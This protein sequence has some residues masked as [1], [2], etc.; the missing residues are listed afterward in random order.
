MSP[1]VFP[2]KY[3]GLP[4]TWAKKIPSPKNPG[5]MMPAH[6][7]SAGN[8]L[9]GNG[10]CPAF[11][12]NKQA[13]AQANVPGVGTV[14]V[15]EPRELFGLP[16]QKPAPTQSSQDKILERLNALEGTLV[17][18]FQTLTKWNEQIVAFMLNCSANE[19][20]VAIWHR[21]DRI[22][23]SIKILREMIRNAVL[24]DE[25]GANDGS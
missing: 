1:T 12:N 11:N 9:N 3:C 19:E 24:G 23:E 25:E 10:L 22:E 16:P 2:C 5:K 6:I 7:D 17:S 13:G 14:N 15:P 18:G 20:N 8:L 21:F 4:K